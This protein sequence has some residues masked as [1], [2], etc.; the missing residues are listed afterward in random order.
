MPDLCENYRAVLDAVRQ[1][2]LASGRDP[3]S[4]RVLAV[5]KTFPADDI[6]ELY[7]Y[8]CRIFGENRVPELLEKAA[9]LPADIEWH[10]IGQLQ[11]NKVRKALSC[12]ALIHSVDS[13]SLL[14]RIER[15][16]GEEDRHPG[17]LIEVNVSGEAS[18]SGCA[19]AELPALAEAAAACRSVRWRGLMTMAPAGASDDVLHEV[20]GG[21]RR[22]RDDLSRRFGLELPELSMGMSGD[23]RVAVEEGA[24]IVRIGSAIFGNRTYPAA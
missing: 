9:A 16:A 18:K 3:A 11:A 7:R 23:W 8:G 21:L 2:A 17:F 15:I 12:A 10:L 24:T 6:A 20:F 4:V 1:T 22:M 19:P 13:V 14:E 5:S